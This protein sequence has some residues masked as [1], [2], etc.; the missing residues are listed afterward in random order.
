MKYIEKS[1]LEIFLKLKG[2]YVDPSE[3][4]I[5]EQK[6]NNSWYKPGQERVNVPKKDIFQSDDLAQIFNDNA[7]LNEF[8]KF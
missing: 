4:A 1:K 5:E 8:R 3:T 2:Y 6:I 7:L